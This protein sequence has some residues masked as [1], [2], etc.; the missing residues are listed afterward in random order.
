METLLVII[1][2][3]LCAS[4]VLAITANIFYVATQGLVTLCEVIEDIL[5][6]IRRD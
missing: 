1:A 6:F 3:F 2:L 4:V 5:H